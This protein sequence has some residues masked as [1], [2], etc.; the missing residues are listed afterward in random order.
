MHKYITLKAKLLISLC[1]M[2]CCVSATAFWAKKQKKKKEN[3][4]A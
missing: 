2:L 3:R 1:K 4:H